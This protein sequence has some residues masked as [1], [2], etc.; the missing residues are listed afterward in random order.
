MSADGK[1]TFGKEEHLCKQVLID[2]LFGGS[3][4]VISVWPLR[5]VFLL[6]DKK[7]ERDV[8]MQV[9]IS[10]SKRFFKRAVKRNRVKRQIRETFRLQRQEL[11]AL[12]DGM[13]DKQLLVAFI[14]QVDELQTSHLVANRMRKLLSRLVEKLDVKQ[15][16]TSREQDGL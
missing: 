3:A 15:Q 7:D 12:M 6:V 2:Q 4:Q 16:K 13:S 14:W 11:K 8:S 1:F 9:L 10:V 5:V